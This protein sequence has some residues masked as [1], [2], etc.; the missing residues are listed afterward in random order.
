MDTI[1]KLTSSFWKPL[2]L[3]LFS[4]LLWNQIKIFYKY[5]MPRKASNKFE[6]HSSSRLKQRQQISNSCQES[7]M[8]LKNIS[9]AANSKHREKRPVWRYYTMTKPENETYDVLRIWQQYL[10]S[11][12]I[13]SSVP[14]A[15][16]QAKKDKKSSAKD[17]S[18]ANQ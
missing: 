17:L 18:Q 14:S 12:A 4:C 16:L 10:L 9:C 3:L 6:T 7:V 2:L 11:D 1:K 13:Q 8:Q 5:N 15:W